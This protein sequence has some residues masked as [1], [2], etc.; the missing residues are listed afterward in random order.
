MSD[1]ALKNAETTQKRLLLMKEELR[2]Q[3]ADLEK[4]LSTVEA[5]IH[6]WHAYA[7]GD[8]ESAQS[9]G[10]LSADSRNAQGKKSE[11]K[12]VTGNPSKEEVAQVTRELIRKRSAPIP[13]KE[14][15]ELLHNE[16]VQIRGTDRDKVLSTMLWRMKR[17]VVNLPRVGYWLAEEPYPPAKYYGGEYAE[18][19]RR[20]QE[21]ALGEA[22]D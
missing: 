13:R 9:I 7:S 2:E 11:Q 18:Q 3:L 21:R 19:M 8:F 20:N 10:A 16:G 12:K 1:N 22:D 15:L 5:F 14:L 6:N 4:K 17:E